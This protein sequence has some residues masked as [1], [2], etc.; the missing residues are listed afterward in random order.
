MTFAHVSDECDHS[1]LKLDRS[2]RDN[3]RMS[4]I[5]SPRVQTFVQ[6]N[7][8]LAPYMPGTKVDLP[9]NSSL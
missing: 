9:K 4:L 8:K 7:S 1:D 6:K 2:V 3:I 5:M